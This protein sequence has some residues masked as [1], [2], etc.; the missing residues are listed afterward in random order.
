MKL[1][2]SILL[3]AV[4]LGAVVPG[5]A[6]APKGPT[7]GAASGARAIASHRGKSA[8][9]WAQDVLRRE[10]DYIVD[11]SFTE[12]TRNRASVQM[13]A[14][15]YGA[16]NVVRIFQ[17]GP[18]WVRPGEAAMGAIGMMAAAIRLKAAGF[19]IAR[20]DGVLSRFFRTW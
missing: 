16:I 17:K 7:P 10:S 3:L 5:M 13:A 20:Y 4:T 19:D 14:D 2:S 12:S 15:G 9:S 6:D 1:L 11:C 18:D 8:R